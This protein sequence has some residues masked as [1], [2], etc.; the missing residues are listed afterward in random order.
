MRKL[1]LAAALFFV[2]NDLASDYSVFVYRQH[3]RAL[4]LGPLAVLLQ[5]AWAPAI[6]CFALSIMMFPDGRVPA[7][8]L[9]LITTP[10]AGAFA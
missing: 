4:P 2:L 1:L 10:S 3:H 5:P 6:V 7:G 8:P 9:R